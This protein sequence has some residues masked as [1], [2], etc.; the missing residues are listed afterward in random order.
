M[1]LAGRFTCCAEGV[2]AEAE[3]YDGTLLIGPV[4]C[5]PYR[6]AEAILR[7][8]SL[9]RDMPMRTYESDGY[10]VSAAFLRQVDVHIQQVLERGNRRRALSGGRPACAAYPCRKAPERSP[11]KAR[12][13]EG[14]R[15]TVSSSNPFDSNASGQDIKPIGVHDL[16][17]RFEQV[18]R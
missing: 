4:N 17:G 12:S 6:I 11:D 16:S 18:E 14:R 13:I 3:G 8:L 10:A 1:K 5:L 2:D 9:Q 7:P 15:R